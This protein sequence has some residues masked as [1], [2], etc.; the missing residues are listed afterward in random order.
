ML[1]TQKQKQPINC[2]QIHKLR[3][4]SELV[5]DTKSRIH[6]HQPRH[7]LIFAKAER[8]GERRIAAG[9]RLSLGS[10][11]IQSIVVETRLLLIATAVCH[12]NQTRLA[13]HRARSVDAIVFANGAASAIAFAF[14]I[15]LVNRQRHVAQRIWIR[16][17]E[18]F[19]ARRTIAA[20]ARAISTS[21]ASSTNSPR[22]GNATGSHRRHGNAWFRWNTGTDATIEEI[23]RFRNFV[24]TRRTV[25]CAITVD[26][27]DGCRAEVSPEK[28]QRFL[29]RRTRIADLVF[30]F[31]EVKTRLVCPTARTAAR[32]QRETDEA[33]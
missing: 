3:R 27:G 33:E 21:P 23:F 17:R 25:E 13:F 20:S 4:L 12:V 28:R 14:R 29:A 15:R 8:F 31:G 18:E 32:E 19:G 24:T 30:H 22:S 9:K 16:I 5:L 10:F 26:R 11:V 7:Y 6:L 2:N 1:R